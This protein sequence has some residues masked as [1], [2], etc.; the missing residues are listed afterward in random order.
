MKLTIGLLYLFSTS[1]YFYSCSNNDT[2]NKELTEIR[3]PEFA[4]NGK[5]VDSLKKIYNCESI[6]YDNWTEK[7]AT[8]SCL[9]VCLI[10]SNKATS[11]N[12]VDSSSNQLKGIALS[13]KKSLAKPQNYNSI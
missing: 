6:E 2:K 7:D 13:I 1:L 5:T 3:Q 4:D 8:D 12:N 11:A 10:N 9:T